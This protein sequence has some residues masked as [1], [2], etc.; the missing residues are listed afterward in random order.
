MGLMLIGSTA[1]HGET[2]SLSVGGIPWGRGE[3][4]YY[5]QIGD[6]NGDGHDDIFSPWPGFFNSTAGE[7]RAYYFYGSFRPGVEPPNALVEA[8]R[9]PWG[10][11]NYTFAGDFNGDGTEEIVTF[12]GGLGLFMPQALQ[13]SLVTFSVDNHWGAGNY[14]FAG[15]FNGDGIDDIASANG[16]TVFM[17]LG[18][19][20]TICTSPNHVGC[21]RFT[22]T[23]WYGATNQ[24]GGGDYTFAGDFNGDGRADIASMYGSTAYM[25]LSTGAGFT[26]TAWPIQGTW[27]A[28]NYTFAGDFNGDGLDDI[29]TA[30]GNRVYLKYSTGSGF[31]YGGSQVVGGSWGGPAFTW[32]VRKNGLNQKDEIATAVGPTIYFHRFEDAGGG[33]GGGGGPGDQCNPLCP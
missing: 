29:A 23:A 10:A 16:S 3:A 2:Y 4:P 6:F 17:K 27:G 1:A 14:T 19:P 25:K 20:G 11:A 5:I 31:T 26:S 24:W 22:S 33:G 32:V 28:G 8:R 9:E 18:S 7:N 15:D 21:E 12:I 13:N 30:I